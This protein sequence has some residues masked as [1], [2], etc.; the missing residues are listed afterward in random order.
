VNNKALSDI[1]SAALKAKEQCRAALEEA[2][3]NVT[4]QI[5][6][7]AAAKK[8]VSLNLRSSIER[9]ESEFR[10]LTLELDKAEQLLSESPRII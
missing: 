9:D 1:E 6:E 7:W 10:A 5:L 2:S 3:E 4:S 8:W